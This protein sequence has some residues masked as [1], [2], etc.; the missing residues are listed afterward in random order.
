[1]K[2]V[3]YLI[4][5]SGK[6]TGVI[7]DLKQHSGIWEDLHDRLLVESRRREPRESLEKVKARLTRRSRK[8][9]G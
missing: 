6:R 7:L 2:G 9:R 3:S 8:S 1:M 5:E 4:D